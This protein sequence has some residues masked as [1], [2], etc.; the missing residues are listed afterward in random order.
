MA[1]VPY[2]SA[3]GSLMYAMLCTR[4]DIAY[5]ISVT[6]R[7][8]SNPG[9][10]H[11][12]VVK[13]ILKYL[14]RTKD[15]FLIYG[16]GELQLE[17]FTD[18]DFQSDIDDRKFVSGFVFLCNGGTVCWK[19]SNQTT[20]ADSTTEAEYVAACDATKEAI[21]IKKF[22][23]ELEVVPSIELAVPLYSENNGAIAQAKEPRSH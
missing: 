13:N 14:R 6:S 9:L 15:L 3:I 1:K 4:P 12:I 8:Q 16:G 18:S 7:F 23:S 5:A 22:V 2:A 21:W 17:G 11:W 19:S 20:I 10:E